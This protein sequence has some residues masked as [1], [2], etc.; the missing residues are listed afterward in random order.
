MPVPR[1]PARRR[2][3][4]RAIDELGGRASPFVHAGRQ[5]YQPPH[6]AGNLLR[7]HLAEDAGGDRRALASERA[8]RA[9]V[10]RRQAHVHRRHSARRQLIRG[11][12]EP[13]RPPCGSRASAARATPARARSARRASSARSRRFSGSARGMPDRRR[14]ERRRQLAGGRARRRELRHPCRIA[15][16]HR[17]EN[18][19]GRGL[20][21]VEGEAFSRAG[22]ARLKGSRLQRRQRLA[23]QR[24]HGL[25]PKR[26]QGS[27]PP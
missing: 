1:L 22:V 17:H 15:A 14:C 5:P 4:R 2:V 7:C 24:R 23:I 21:F 10:I 18:I 27:D 19:D 16:A 13:R 6:G 20:R 26:R 3:Q 12:A 9:R 25:A 8:G 11:H